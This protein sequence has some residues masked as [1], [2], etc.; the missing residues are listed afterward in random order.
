MRPLVRHFYA[1]TTQPSLLITAVKNSSLAPHGRLKGAVLKVTEIY[2][3][4]ILP[5][6]GEPDWPIRHWQGSGQ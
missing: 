6:F 1:V 4:C 3:R 5:V 2:S